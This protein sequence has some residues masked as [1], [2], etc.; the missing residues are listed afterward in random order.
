MKI[1]ELRTK[2]KEELQNLLHDYKKEG[3]NLRFQKVSGELANF[4]RIREVKRTTAKILMLLGQNK[5]TENNK[6]TGKK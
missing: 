2:S 1:S 6:K 4:A 5:E 3:F